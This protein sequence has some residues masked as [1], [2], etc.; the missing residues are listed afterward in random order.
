MKRAF[1]T[2]KDTLATMLGLTLPAE[3]P[4]FPE[5]FYPRDH[6]LDGIWGGYLFVIG[7]LVVGNGGFAGPPNEVGCVEIGYEIAPALRNLGHAT[8]AARRLV[9][10]AWERGARQVIAHTAAEWNASNRVL[11][12]LGMRFRAALPNPELG[13]V[14]LFAMDRQT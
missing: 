2:S 14:W 9:A 3:W 1:A 7:D 6:E 4:Q 8:A 12:K 11:D 5:A 13:S 10:L